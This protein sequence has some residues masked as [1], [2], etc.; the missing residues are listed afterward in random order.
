[1]GRCGLFG[2]IA[3]ILVGIVAWCIIHFLSGVSP[4]EVPDR[5]LLRA[6]ASFVMPVAL[7][8]LIT[9]LFVGMLLPR[10]SKAPPS[11]ASEDQVGPLFLIFYTLGIVA[12]FF[13]WLPIIFAAARNFPVTWQADWPQPLKALLG[14]AKW[15]QIKVEQIKVY[16]TDSFLEDPTYFW[17]TDDSAGALALVFK[18]WRLSPMDH[19]DLTVARFWHSMPSALCRSRDPNRIEYFAN[20]DGGDKYFV[21][22]DKERGLLVVWYWSEWSDD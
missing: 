18:R 14:D 20:W 8:G 19:R 5:T 16:R 1:M 2:V 7:V 9:G 11:L 13:C 4:F 22:R 15:G 10:R 6:I 12:L 3:G 21:M 17:Q